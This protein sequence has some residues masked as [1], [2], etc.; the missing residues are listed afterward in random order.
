M[1]LTSSACASDDQQK[2]LF[3]LK[4]ANEVKHVVIQKPKL[5]CKVV[6]DIYQS[7]SILFRE[8]FGP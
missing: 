5:S 4:Q 2:K 7:I 6:W 8:T 3:L 1:Q